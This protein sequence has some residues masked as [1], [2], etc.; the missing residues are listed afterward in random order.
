MAEFRYRFAVREDIP[1][2]LQFIRE[3]ADYEQMQDEVIA[4]EPTLEEWIFDKQK[5]EVIFALDGE[6]EAG[7][8]IRMEE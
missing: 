5:A 2:I 7:F 4:D 1:L 8:D 6:T 3:L